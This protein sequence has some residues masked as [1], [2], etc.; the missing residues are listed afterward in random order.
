[1]ARGRDLSQQ[2]NSLRQRM[3]TCYLAAVIVALSACGS[4]MPRVNQTETTLTSSCRAGNSWSQKTTGELRRTVT[5]TDSLSSR[6]RAAL[7]LPYVATSPA[8]EHV[9]DEAECSR[10]AAALETRYADGVSRR[11]LWVFRIG[12]TRFG[13]SDGTIG[14]RGNIMVRIF[15][16]S[17]TY[18]ASLD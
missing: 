12:S 14:A 11:P 8:V 6:L 16:T 17:Y 1:M 15:D 9:L 13:V 10:A 3:A 18:L 7:Q 4:R 5:G 2:C